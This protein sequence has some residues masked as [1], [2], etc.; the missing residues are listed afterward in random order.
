MFIPVVASCSRFDVVEFQPV[1]HAF[2]FGFRVTF[3][4]RS[5]RGFESDSFRYLKTFAGQSLN[6][7]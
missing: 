4:F 7:G 1:A 5:D 2:H 6:V 3:I